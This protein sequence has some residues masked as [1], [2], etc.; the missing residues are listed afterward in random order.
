MGRENKGALMD[1]WI[2]V[3]TRQRIAPQHYSPNSLNPLSDHTKINST[4]VLRFT[5]TIEKV[6][7]YFYRTTVKITQTKNSFLSR[8]GDH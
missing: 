3:Y 2:D 6:C 7:H 8:E 5:A 1:R 4:I